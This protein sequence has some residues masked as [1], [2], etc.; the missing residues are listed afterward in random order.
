MKRNHCQDPCSRATRALILLTLRFVCVGVV[1][2]QA[3]TPTVL[4]TFMQTDA[5]APRGN[6][7]Q[8]RDGNM[9]GGG[10]AC[11]G[12]GTGAIYK[13]SPA[14]AQ[15]VFF[16]FPQQWTVAISIVTPGGTA[17]SPTKFTV[18]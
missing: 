6:I 12:N 2:A 3:Q 9:Y 16:S 7:V 11:G 13:I 18:N 5:C 1:P 17:V 14:G 8:G 15:S 10:G 4:P